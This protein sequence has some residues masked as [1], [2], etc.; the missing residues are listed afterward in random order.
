MHPSSVSNGIPFFEVQL[1]IEMLVF[2]NF[3]K[4]HGFQRDCYLAAS[5]WYPGQLDSRRGL[6][7]LRA[8][9]NISSTSV[10]I[11]TEIRCSA[12]N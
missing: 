11:N 10:S 9:W 5:P 1:Y 2:I 8:A 6:H 7:H 4:L 3:V 12:F